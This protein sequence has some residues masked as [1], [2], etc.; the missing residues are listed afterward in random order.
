MKRTALSLLLL[1]ICIYPALGEVAKEPLN[2][3][4]QFHGGAD[5]STGFMPGYQ[6]GPDLGFWLGIGLNNRMDGLWGIDYYTMP[7]E[8]I[9]GTFGTRTNPVTAI[10]PTDDI[11]MTVNAR[12]Y[13]SD[14]RDEIRQ[15]FNVAPYL[16]A[17][18]GMDF[19]IDQWPRDPVTM[20]YNASYD[21]LFS[22]N[23]GGGVAFPISSNWLFY[24]EGMDHMIL[25][26]GL[27]QVFSIRGGFKVMLDSE[28][29]D[30]F[31]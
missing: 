2:F 24:T 31:R 30:P 17:G 11:A 14:K 20:F 7:G 5:Y 29:V 22:T 28:H 15:R 25:W 4:L 16:V 18:I 1:A 3:S 27:T 21:W 23:L 12:W 10:K 13:L 19:L 26:Q 9:P 6:P 8:I